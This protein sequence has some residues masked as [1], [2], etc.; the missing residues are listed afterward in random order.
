L[1]QNRDPAGK[2][3]PH[4]PQVAP[5]RVPQPRQKFDPDGFPYWHR[6]HFMP[7]LQPA[8]LVKIGTVG[9]EYLRGSH[10]VKDIAASCHAPAV[11]LRR[12]RTVKARP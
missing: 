4:A 7:S 3:L 2:S 1:L 8:A 10:A 11:L 12:G 5:K 9:R 6:G